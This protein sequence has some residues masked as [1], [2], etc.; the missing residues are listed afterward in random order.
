MK[1]IRYILYIFSLVIVLGA[2]VFA[3]SDRRDPDRNYRN[4]FQRDYRIFSP[5][6]PDRISF[7]GEE[8]PLDIYYVRESLDR[9]IMAVTYMHSSTQKMFKQAHRYFPVIEP[10]LKEYGIPEDFKF[11]VVAESN[12]SNVVSPAGAEGM[13]QFLQ[14]T[15]RT[16]GLEIN[17]K[18]DER[19]NLKKATEAA[20]QYLLE[21]RDTFGNWTLAAASYNRGFNGMAEALEN[22]KVD[23]YYDLYLNQETARYIYRILAAKEIY[24]NP[25][26]YGFYM[27]E[28]DFY[29]PIETYTIVVDTT[30]EDLPAFALERGIT[31]KVIREF[32][33]WIHSYSLPNKSGRTYVLTLPKKGAIKVKPVKH[34]PG[35]EETFFNDTLRIDELY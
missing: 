3:I 15:G 27:R 4:A 23:N 2:F 30:I 29:P 28:Q 5:E 26:K 10:I 20:C 24:N 19:Y 11:L 18:I 33:P 32:N 8:V 31:Y 14:S 25:V 9:E 17:S 35:S 21:A 13:W 1:F 12:L 7:A 34:K 6:V 22:Q 16:Y